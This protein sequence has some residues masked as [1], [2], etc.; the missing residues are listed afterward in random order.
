MNFIYL[1]AVIIWQTV[2]VHSHRLV[3]A[4]VLFTTATYG[5]YYLF[6]IVNYI[7][8]CILQQFELIFSTPNGMVDNFISC[9]NFNAF[10]FNSSNVE[11]EQK[12]TNSFM[13]H[14]TYQFGFECFA[15]IPV[16]NWHKVHAIPIDFCSLLP[17]SSLC[18]AVLLHLVH[19][20]ELNTKCERI[21][22]GDL[23]FSN[24]LSIHSNSKPLVSN[25]N[26]SPLPL[27]ILCQWLRQFYLYVSP[28]S[29]SFFTMNVYR[30]PIP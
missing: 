6:A 16:L 22:N 7:T 9:L 15:Q 25:V 8:F 29:I 17:S 18:S 23:C 5:C 20:P 19:L 3:R 21:K 12:T 4:Y 28:F 13:Q 14:N 24:M 10:L 2:L 26:F 30:K 1:F 11:H 27:S